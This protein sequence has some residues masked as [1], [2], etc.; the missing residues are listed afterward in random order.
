[1]LYRTL[2]RS[3]RS[4]CALKRIETFTIPQPGEGIAEV[5][6]LSWLIKPGDKVSEYEVICEARSDKGFIE[7]KTEYDGIIKE[8]L[9]KPQDMAPIGGQLYKID[10]DD[11]QYPPK[12]SV[13]SASQH[14]SKPIPAPLAPSSESVKVLTTPAV[15][16]LAKANKIDL[17]QLTGTGRDGR[18][19]KEDIINYLNPEESLQT[20]AEI[21]PKPLTQEEPLPRIVII[22][23][24]DRTK[25]LTALQKAMLKSMTEALKI[26]HMTYCEDVNMDN[27]I[28][29]RDHL[30]KH[31]PEK[32]K[33]TY[34]PFFMKALSMAINDFPIVNSSLSQ[35]Q[36]EYTEHSS[37]NI[38]IAMDTTAG[39][40]VPNVRNCESLSV[41]EIAMEIQRLQD[42][43]KKGRL[44][45]SDIRGG[46]ISLSNIGNIG[47]TYTRPI[48]LAPQ[49]LIGGLCSIRPQ[50][51]LSNG[52]VV[53]KR[54]ISTSWSGD[55]RILDGA[56]TARFVKRWKELIE[57][58]SLMLL[59]L[60]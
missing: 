8:L 50:L 41:I 32:V 3:F 15:R 12:G 19:T 17:T 11:I 22:K 60:K 26:P 38:S 31:I 30:K 46:T 47:G 53:E 7:Y 43:G 9:Y 34:M 25:K 48:I 2:G 21:K 27:L 45:D 52:I 44:T 18:I 58:P 13:H 4:S 14:Y 1:M 33:L 24:E 56:T 59:S 55:H 29:I 40:M 57:Q 36:S 37:H 5:E 42:L 20:E 6:I 49:V 10:I 28:Q 16:H 39:L 23:G 35:D 51:V 54:I